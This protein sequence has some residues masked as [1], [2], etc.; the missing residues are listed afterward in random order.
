[1]AFILNILEQSS[2]ICM[3]LEFSSLIYHPTLEPIKE[4]SVKI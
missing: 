3:D 1:M 2:Y 4:D